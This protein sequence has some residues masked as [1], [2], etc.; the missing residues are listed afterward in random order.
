MKVLFLIILKKKI[1][2]NVKP[3]YK[4]KIKITQAKSKIFGN[5]RMAN[6]N[7]KMIN[8]KNRKAEKVL[9]P[10]MRQIQNNNF[11]KIEKI[12]ITSLSNKKEN[13]E[14][15]CINQI[16]LENN[17]KEIIINKKIKKKILT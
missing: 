6:E 10:N 9:S 1:Q 8:N 11:E 16:N 12:N 14:N 4:K 15:R 3:I 13:I 17:N 7:N 5:K 2:P